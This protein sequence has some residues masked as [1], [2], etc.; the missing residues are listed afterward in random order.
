M[1]PSGRKAIVISVGSGSDSTSSSTIRS[2]SGGKKRSS[3]QDASAERSTPQVQVVHGVVSR[4]GGCGA[5]PE[6]NLMT[7]NLPSD[8]GIPPQKKGQV[9]TRDRV[10][11]DV[12]C[13]HTRGIHVVMFMS[14]AIGRDG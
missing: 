2:G 13:G 6:A 7:L 4:Y 8:S 11:L 10:G 3:A 12:G 5:G 1:A 14:Q 9:E